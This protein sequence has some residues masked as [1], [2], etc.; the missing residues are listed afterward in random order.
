MTVGLTA[1]RERISGQPGIER[2]DSTMDAVAD[3]MHAEELA[4]AARWLGLAIALGPIVEVAD[5]GALITALTAPSS[6]GFGL[7]APLLKVALFAVL[8]I[9]AAVILPKHEPRNRWWFFMACAIPVVGWIG[10]MAWSGDLRAVAVVPLLALPYA[11][12]RLR[13]A[14]RRNFTG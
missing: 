2:Y 11:G 13:H 8:G 10:H 7:V 14:D 9:A 3:R 12:A 6:M 1:H 4:G 5:R